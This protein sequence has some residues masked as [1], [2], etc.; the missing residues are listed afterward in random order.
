VAALKIVVKRV[1]MN[2]MNQSD[3]LAK[4]Y[5]CQY[6]QADTPTFCCDHVIAEKSFF[7]II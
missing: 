1:P 6:I 2:M 5:N 3:L 7:L 4:L